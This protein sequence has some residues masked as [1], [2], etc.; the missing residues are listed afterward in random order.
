MTRPALVPESQDALSGED[1]RTTLRRVHGMR[2]MTHAFQRMRSADGFSHARASAFAIALLLVEGT[3]AV[4]GLAVALGSPAFSR[5]VTA[6]A[7][8]AVP[9]PAGRLLTSA[10]AQAQETGAS[11]QYTA[12]LVGLLAALVTGTTAM[13]QFERSCNRIYGID[14]D[15]PSV[16]KYTRAFLLALTVGV[17]SAFAVSMMVLGRPIAESIENSSVSLIWLWGRW[18]LAIIVLVA[19][20][21]A[22]L[23]FSPNRRQPAY[24]WLLYG[25]SVSVGLIVAARWRWRCSSTGAPPSVTR[26]VHSPG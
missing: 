11:H 18:P 1:A 8:M 23:K 22:L 2:L 9:G 19:A 17:V 4:I 24:S 6:A 12:L 20:L 16:Q 21:T 3:I 7:E 14:D 10:V 26:T 25:A 15:R 5:T 13:G